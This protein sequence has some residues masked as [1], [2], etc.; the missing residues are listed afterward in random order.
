MKV[1]K[2]SESN[3]LSL[4][5]KLQSD[6]PVLILYFAEWCG[7]CVAFKPTW[8][9]IKKK[10]ETNKDIHVIEVENS[11]IK[12]LPKTNQSVQAFPTIQL[13]KKGKVKEYTGFRMMDSIL[14]FVNTNIAKVKTIKD[15]APK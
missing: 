8:D 7:H 1:L 6:K 12:H 11:N 15:K 3:K 2:A 9:A 10:L 13:I 14:S 4:S 5:K